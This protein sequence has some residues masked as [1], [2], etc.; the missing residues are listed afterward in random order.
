MEI[1]YDY[2][3]RDTFND[4]LGADMLWNLCENISDY[5]LLRLATELVRL[6]TQRLDSDLDNKE[7]NEEYTKL[8]SIINKLEE[9]IKNYV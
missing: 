6:A 2:D 9:I 7:I 3:I 1:N 5:D 4:I 8:N